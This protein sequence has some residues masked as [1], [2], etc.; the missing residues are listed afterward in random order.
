MNNSAEQIGIAQTLSVT[1]SGQ[2][3]PELLD[4][5]RARGRQLSDWA[6]TLITQFAFTPTNGVTH[7]LL[8]IQ[9]ND[10]PDG[11]RT[12]ANIRAEAKR[13]GCPDMPSNLALEVATLLRAKY[14]QSELGSPYFTILH[15]PLPDSNGFPY[16]FELYRNDKDDWLDAW[17][18][19]EGYKWVPGFKF[20]FLAPNESC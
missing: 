18:A 7:K 8:V 15:E 13:R 9:G 19:S 17:L 10:L 16:V 11:E 14:S 5:L 1:T 2:T 6:N 4:A 3:A 12:T 20:I